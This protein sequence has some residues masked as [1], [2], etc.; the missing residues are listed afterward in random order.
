MKLYLR[1]LSMHLKSQMQYK[2]SFFL[3]M[4]GQFLTSFSVLLGLYFMFSRFNDV[5]GFT[6]QQ[7]LLCF[8]TV[9]MAF[10]IAECFGRGFD[11]FPLMLGN[12]EFDRVL[13]RPRR[14]VF[15]VLASKMDF[16]RLGRLLQAVLVFCYALP[17]SGVT[18]TPDKLVTL[19]LM[20]SCG[21]V[22]FFCLFLIYAGLTFFTTEG[23]EFMNIFT[24]GAREFG[25]YPFSVYGRGVLS[26]LTFVI[27]L[28][29]FQYYPLLYLLDIKTSVLYMLTP[30]IGLLFTI[31]S[32]V[33]WR[34]G[35]RR[36]RSTGS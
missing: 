25:R 6:F 12:G 31:P 24:D 34:F 26:F 13:V 29:L 33:F 2:V 30:V 32:Y 28:A 16:T 14:A 1:F 18:W 8:A 23:L 17:A 10:S 7:S 9:L 27:P 4:A 22:V 5:D 36:Y 11:V 15:Q 20:V 21:S 3:S 19:F 35:L